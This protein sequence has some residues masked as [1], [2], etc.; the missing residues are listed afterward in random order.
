MRLVS[1]ERDTGPG[2][3]AGPG[4]QGRFLRA[5]DNIEVEVDGLGTPV[6]RVRDE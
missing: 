1:Y 2:A 6:N 3:G 4:A 5:G